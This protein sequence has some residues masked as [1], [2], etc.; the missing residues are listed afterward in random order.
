V[1][2]TAIEPTRVL[3]TRNGTGLTGTFKTG[4]AR[5]LQVAG[6]SNV[7]ATAVA[8]AG[9]VTVTQ[10][11]AAG[12]LAVRPTPQNAP[13]TS[14]LNFPLHDD[15]ANSVTGTGLATDGTLAI[16][17]VSESAGAQTHVILDI[18]GYFS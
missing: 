18:T 4:V 9:N 16:T 17:F 2:Y 10:A 15:R 7:P 8:I 12:Y 14:S 1:N 11:S 3:D 6:V 5:T 13:S